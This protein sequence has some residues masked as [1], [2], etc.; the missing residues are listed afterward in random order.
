MGYMVIM[1]INKQ[2]KYKK[3]RQNNHKKRNNKNKR[4]NN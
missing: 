4:K 1:D 3:I 2:L